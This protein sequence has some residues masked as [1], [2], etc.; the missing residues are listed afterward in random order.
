MKNEYIAGDFVKFA[1]NT[2]TIV[3]FEENFLHNKICYAMIL[4]KSLMSIFL[5]RKEVSN[6]RA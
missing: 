3:N 6:E 2:Y 1:T 5:K 4:M